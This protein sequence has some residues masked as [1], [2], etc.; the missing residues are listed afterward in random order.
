ML[1]LGILGGTVVQTN[2]RHCLCL[3]LGNLFGA[4]SNPQ[5]V[6][7]FA[8]LECAGRTKMLT[9]T[10]FDQDWVWGMSAKVPMHP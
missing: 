9:K 8:W 2:V 4:T 1:V 5:F 10:D 6:A 7:A 3:T